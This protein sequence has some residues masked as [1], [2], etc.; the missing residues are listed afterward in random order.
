[1]ERYATISIRIRDLDHGVVL[2]SMITTLKPWIFAN[3]LCRKQPKDLDELQARATR[4]IQMEELSTFRNQVCSAKQKKDDH[5][6]VNHVNKPW[7]Y[8]FYINNGIEKKII[9]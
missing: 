4:Y 9:L 8:F 2:H 7:Y 3:N 1:M 6:S 5:T